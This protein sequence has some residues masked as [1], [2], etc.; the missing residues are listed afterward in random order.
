MRLTRKPDDT[1]QESPVIQLTRESVDREARSVLRYMGGKGTMT[2]FILPILNQIPHQQY[3]EP[4]GGGASILLAKKPSALD[5]YNDVDSSIVN[6]FRVLRDPEKFKVFQRLCENTPYSREEFYEFRDTFREQTDDV[7]RAHRYFCTMRMSFGGTGTSFGL[8]VKG[9]A[10]GGKA[11]ATYVNVVEYLPE[12]RERLRHVQIEHQDFRKIFNTYDRPDA[13]FFADP[14]YVAASRRHGEYEH[15]MSDEDHEELVAILS[16]LKGKAVLSG[17]P[18]DI[19]KP[20]EDAGWERRD[21]SI[22]CS[23]AGRT[24]ASGLQGEGKVS[25]LQRRIE[26]VWIQPKALRSQRQNLI[27]IWRARAQKSASPTS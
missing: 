10:A 13:L 7:H 16:N 4:F 23:L 21:V 27:E 18:N 14:P 9:D 25:A 8:Q 20:L 1:G 17:Y 3:I 11:P 26:S 15:E 2:P 22:T 24:R 5:V 6:L 19:Y 12:V